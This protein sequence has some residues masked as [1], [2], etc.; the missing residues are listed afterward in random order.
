MFCSA[1]KKPV[2]TNTKALAQ[3]YALTKAAND[4]GEPLIFGLETGLRIMQ[5]NTIIKITRHATWRRVKQKAR[6]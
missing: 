2:K 6:R 5:V 4:N 3:T 1:N